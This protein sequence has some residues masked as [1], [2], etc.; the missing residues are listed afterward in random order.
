MKNFRSFAN[1]LLCFLFLPAFAL[2]AFG[3]EPTVPTRITDD[4]RISTLS[5]QKPSSL[6]VFNLYASTVIDPGKQDTSFSI[7][8]FNTLQSAFVHLFFIS[9]N[10]SVADAFICMTPNQ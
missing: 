7:T 5:D 10:C 3:A 6:L 2:I 1:H 4:A 9:G 8:N